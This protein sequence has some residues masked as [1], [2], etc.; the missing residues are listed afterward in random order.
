MRDA[1]EPLDV[2][3]DRLEQPA[4][5]ALTTL[6]DPHPQPRARPSVSRATSAAA[7]RGARREPRGTVL[8]L[9]PERR[10][11][12]CGGRRRIDE[13][14]VLALVAIPGVQDAV[15]P[16]PVVRQDHQPLRLHVEPAGRPEA[17]ATRVDEGHHRAAATLVARR[18]EE[19]AR[20]VDGEVDRPPAAS[21]GLPSTS[22][23][24]RP[25]RRVPSPACRPLT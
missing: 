21:S 2:A 10:R 7:A 11:S 9:D 6:A 5:L 18:A 17:L 8:E 20:L 4:D 13:R 19:P 16:L 15:R 1:Y 22:I 23:R 3:A 12:S 24:S 14:R 25:G